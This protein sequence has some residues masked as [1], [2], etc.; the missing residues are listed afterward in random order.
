MKVQEHAVGGPAAA[1]LE[2]PIG[3]EPAKFGV[4][5]GPRTD[6][7]GLLV[8]PDRGADE[9]V[10]ATRD[11]STPESAHEKRQPQPG[12]TVGQNAD[13]AAAGVMTELYHEGRTERR[14]KHDAKDR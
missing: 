14:A 5:Q 1:E 10:A 7:G 9:Q 2:Q 3:C 13:R 11:A 8:G 4:A 12:P 6:V